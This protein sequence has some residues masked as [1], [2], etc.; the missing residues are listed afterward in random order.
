MGPKNLHFR[1]G[2]VGQWGVTFRV[3]GESLSEYL[4]ATEM[5]GMDPG[6]SLPSRM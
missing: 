1:L 3:L 5:A 6:L 2:R 4:V